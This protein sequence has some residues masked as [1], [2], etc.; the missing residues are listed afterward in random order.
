MFKA[1]FETARPY[2][3]WFF[4][5]EWCEFFTIIIFICLSLFFFRGL[6]FGG[7]VG[8]IH[9]VVAVAFV[10]FVFWRVVL[11]KNDD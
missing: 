2:L 9:I 11:R 8:L 6:F 4:N 5:N 7:G 3:R 10:A 1:M